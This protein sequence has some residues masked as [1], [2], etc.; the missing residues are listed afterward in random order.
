MSTEQLNAFSSVISVN[1]YTNDYI[2]GIS[3]FLTPVKSPEFAKDQFV[4]SYLNT[5]NYI[6]NQIEISKNIPQEDILDAINIKI[7]DEL[8]LDQAI[9]Y[10]IQYIETFSKMEGENRNFQVFIVDPLEIIDTYANVVEQ[11]KY[12]D[13]ITPA[14]LLI[15][16]LYT[17]DIIDDNGI[18]CFLYFEEHDAFISIYNEKDFIYSKSLKYSLTYMHE[19]FCELYGEKIEYNEFIHFLT[20]EN[21]KYTTSAYKEFILRLYKEIFANINDILTY[22]KKAFEIE[23]VEHIYIGSQV[24]MSSKLYE[25]AE[26]ELGIASSDFNFDYGFEENDNYIDQMH[27]LMH[28]TTTID[29]EE[30]Y[31]CNFSSFHRPPKFIKRESGRLL[32]L[33]AASFVIAFA[34]P[35]TFWILLYS[36]E[37]QYSLLQQ[38]YKEV[39]A[40]KSTRDATIKSRL[41]DKQ[42]ALALL[43]EEEDSYN[44]KKNTLVTI[45]DVKVNYPMKA[46][47]ITTLANDLNKYAVKIQR[48]AYTEAE[49]KKVFTLYLTSSKDKKITN[50]LEYFT[51]KYDQKFHFSIE[52]IIFDEDK[53]LYFSELKVNIL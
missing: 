51:K 23:K 26:V 53:K 1:P 48:I 19:R 49:K 36:Q 21:L 8:G 7:Y 32:I 50:L 3:S 11:I 41:A 18:H 13:V 46:K 45:H 27:A 24:N 34:Y 39:H 37:L 35:V 6:N 20:Q 25:I 15:K 2:S 33:G 30:K 10:Q 43:K 28:I 9:E 29:E 31:P 38:T 12:I 17:K 14:P 52:K 42:K 16:S 47:L 44:S 4:T 40:E 5:Q 22:T